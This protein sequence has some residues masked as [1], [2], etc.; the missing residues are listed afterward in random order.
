MVIDSLTHVTPDGRWFRTD[1]DASE[2]RLLREMEEANVDRAVVVALAGYISN[3]FVLEVCRRHPDRL[4]PG[5]SFNPVV[6]PTDADAVREFRAQLQHAPYR[7][8]KLHPR[9]NGYDPLDSRCM[10]ILEELSSWSETMPVWMDSLFYSREC[11]LRKSLVDTI[12]EIVVR[13][14]TLRFV[15]LHAGGPWALQV[16][17]AIRDCPNTYLDIS[18]TLHRYATSSVGVDLHYLLETFE[19]RLV[20]GS[21]FP[22]I[23]PLTALNDFW[24]LADGIS[25]DKCAKVL[26]ENLAALLPRSDH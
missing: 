11:V 14:P 20:F 18:F 16:A 8:L 24:R 23:G 21:D 9:L 10:S 13:F 4:E 12:H 22:E 1:C 7:V 6:Y 2:A 17:E 19:R 5:A 15:L 26:G 25:P 3:E